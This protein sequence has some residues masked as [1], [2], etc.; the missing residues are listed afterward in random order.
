MTDVQSYWQEISGTSNLDGELGSC[1]LGFRLCH[2]AYTIVCNSREFSDKQV[3][4]ASGSCPGLV[5]GL[6]TATLRNCTCNES[7]RPYESFTVELVMCLCELLL[8]VEWD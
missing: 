7:H 4:H 8:L 6:G 5:W 2:R 3:F 1:A